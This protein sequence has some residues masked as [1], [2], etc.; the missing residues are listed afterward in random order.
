MAKRHEIRNSTAEF[1]IFQLENKEQGI[2]VMY[3]DE[4]ICCTQKAMAALFDVGVPAISKHLANIFETG[5]LKEDATISKMETVQQEG[6]REVKRTVVMYKLDAIIAVGYRVNSIRATQFRQWA[7][8]VLRQYA[9]RGYVLDKKF[10]EK[11]YEPS[12]T[13]PEGS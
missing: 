13:L 5:E 10:C 8:S 1:L 7:T 6:N 4:T 3:A 9:I 11:P 2:E 12:P